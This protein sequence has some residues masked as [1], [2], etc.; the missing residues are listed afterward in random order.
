LA[1]ASGSLMKMSSFNTNQFTELNQLLS[2][3]NIQISSSRL[4]DE[5]QIFNITG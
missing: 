3:N 2:E 4:R 5:K 1:P